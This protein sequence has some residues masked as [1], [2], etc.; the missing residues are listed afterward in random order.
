MP[1]IYP[2]NQHINIIENISD[3]LNRCV[4]RTVANPK[5]LNQLREK[6]LYEWNNLPQNYVQPF[7]TSMRRRSL[8][9][10]KSAG[11]IPTDMEE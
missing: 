7:V 5:A 9:V 11:D 3:E 1:S 8:A 4:R 2:H 6:I 10:K